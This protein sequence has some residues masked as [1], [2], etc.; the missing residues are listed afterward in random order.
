MIEFDE[1]TG[2]INKAIFRLFK[3]WEKWTKLKCPIQ[4]DMLNLFIQDSYLIGWFGY[5]FSLGECF[6]NIVNDNIE[7]IK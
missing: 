4:K 3:H 7:V 6:Y 1:N 5:I 2:I